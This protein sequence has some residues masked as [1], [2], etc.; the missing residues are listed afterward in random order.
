MFLK[1]NKPWQLAVFPAIRP[2]ATKAGDRGGPG[3]R[4]Q[5]AG[6][7]FSKCENIIGECFPK[8]LL[9]THASEHGGQVRLWQDPPVRACELDGR[10]PGIPRKWITVNQLT[11]KDYVIFNPISLPIYQQL[12]NLNID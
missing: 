5:R 11:L 7:I 9:L 12:L 8:A 2:F 3:Q 6:G 4:A 10:M 1:F